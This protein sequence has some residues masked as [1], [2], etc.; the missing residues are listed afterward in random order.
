[1]GLW[2]S[3]KRVAKAVVRVVVKAVSTI[4]GGLVGIFDLLF[5]FLNWPPKNLT[6]HIVVLSKLGDIEQKRLAAALQNSI[7][8]TRRVLKER[9]N[10]NLRSYSN[11]YVEWFTGSVP[12]E[13]LE[14]SCCNDSDLFLGEF[15]VSGEFYAQHTAGWVGVPISL[16]FPITVFIVDTVHCKSGCSDFWRADYVVIKHA[17]LEVP[18]VPHPNSLMVHEVG[19]ACNLWHSGS[20]GNIMY[21]EP[22]RGDGAKWFQKNMLRGSR[23]VTYW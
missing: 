19:H 4:W 3:I 13:A 16:R 11:E 15:G 9:F 17:G 22:E 1:M 6:L 5:G 7:D 18:S 23:H 12:P 20:K 10:V 14:P 21:K 2:S 8:E